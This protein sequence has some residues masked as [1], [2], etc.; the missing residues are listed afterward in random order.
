MKKGVGSGLDPGSEPEPDPLVRGTDPGI[1]IR[2][3][4]IPN[5]AAPLGFKTALWMRNEF[6]GTWIFLFSWFWILHELSL[7]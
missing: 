6:L 7:M 5:T 3:K 4:M 2:T 1:W